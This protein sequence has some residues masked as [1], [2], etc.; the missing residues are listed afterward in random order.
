MKVIDSIQSAR[1]RSVEAL[2][3]V[4]FQVSQVKL[5]H[6][7]TDSARPD[8]RPDLRVDILAHVEV[9][10]H[11]HMLVC[12]VEASG[13]PDHVR[14]ALEE[15]RSDT[16][17]FAGNAT[18]VLIAPRVSAEA[19]A[20]CMAN[21]AGFLDLEGNARLHL[22]EVFIGKRSMPQSTRASHSTANSRASVRLAGVA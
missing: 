3:A 13:R 17:R 5:K 10:G 21:A 9:H 4:L 14:M 2:K 7:D 19:Q 1:N 12:K 15:L 22:G 6:I 8:L 18:P 11:S 20:M 16:A